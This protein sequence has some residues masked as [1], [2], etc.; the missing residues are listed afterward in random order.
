MKN[1]KDPIRNFTCDLQASSTVLQPSVPPCKYKL[2]GI[3]GNSD[4]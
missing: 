1:P 3:N 4:C 2:N